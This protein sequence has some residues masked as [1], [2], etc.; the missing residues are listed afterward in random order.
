VPVCISLS[1]SLPLPLPFSLSH[2]HALSFTHT[3]CAL[4]L[5]H[6]HCLTLQPCPAQNVVANPPLLRGCR[7]WHAH[8]PPSNAHMSPPSLCAVV[9]LIQA[10]R[11]TSSSRLTARTTP[12]TARHARPSM[13]GSGWRSG[14]SRIQS[15]RYPCARRVGALSSLTSRSLG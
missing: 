2:M 5:A 10:C 4:L 3:Y 13:A 9:L 1:P 6:S 7:C 15:R 8:V 11:A 12:P 14:Y